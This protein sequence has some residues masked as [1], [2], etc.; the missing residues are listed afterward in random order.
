MDLCGCSRAMVYSPWKTI[1]QV[2]PRSPA[3]FDVVSLPA[4][5]VIGQLLKKHRG[6]PSQFHVRTDVAA[7]EGSAAERS[8]RR[9]TV[10]GLHA[11]ELSILEPTLISRALHRNED[12]RAVRFSALEGSLEALAVGPRIDAFALGPS[13]DEATDVRIGAPN[14]IG[15][16]V[17]DSDALATRQAPH[18][19]STCVRYRTDRIR[20]RRY[21]E[22]RVHY[23]P[24][25][26]S[27]RY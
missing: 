10:L 19:R 16:K 27:R 4:D 26:P 18:G 24:V 11:G 15:D 14:L 17:Y 22:D 20:G 21:L 2:R 5:Q 3:G 13:L 23:H 12:A 7:R 6:I 8:R 1:D 25:V 9:R